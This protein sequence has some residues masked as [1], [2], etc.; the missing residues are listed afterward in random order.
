MRYTLFIKVSGTNHSA[1]SIVRLFLSLAVSSGLISH[2]LLGIVN[3]DA[4]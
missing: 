3:V 2:F 4:S 1:F